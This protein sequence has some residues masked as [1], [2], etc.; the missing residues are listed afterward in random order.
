MTRRTRSRRARCP[1]GVG[2]RE[3]FLPDNALF[4]AKLLEAGVDS[5]LHV[6]EGLN[7][8]YPM[9]PTPE[10]HRARRDLVR[11]VTGEPTV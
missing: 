5:T 11:L 3:I 9:F 8:V 10:G 2:T 7:H 4:H 6:G 1:S